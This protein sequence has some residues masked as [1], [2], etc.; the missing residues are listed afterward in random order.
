MTQRMQSQYVQF[1][2]SGSAALQI[3]PVEH[4]KAAP[5]EQ[6]K[7]RVQK[8]IRVFVDPVAIVGMVVA[9]FLCVAIFVG[10][11]QLNAVRQDV[12]QM[13]EYV[14]Y[15]QHQHKSIK[16]KYTETY[17]LEDIEKTALALG[18]VPADQVRHSR[19]SVVEPVVEEEPSVWEN[20]GTFLSGLFA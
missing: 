11:F 13:E 14:V 10:M 16:M 2:T 17:N 6:T 8:R 7:P 15:L 19:I 4:K 3:H 20:V 18:M 1:Y 5:V 9:L 12:H